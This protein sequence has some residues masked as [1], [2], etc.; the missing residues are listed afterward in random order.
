[1]KDN[2]VIA[3]IDMGSAKVTTIIAQVNL[4]ESSL[5]KSVNIVGV[6]SVDSKGVRKGLL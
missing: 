6:A 2:K 3:A 4:N 1:M 5:E